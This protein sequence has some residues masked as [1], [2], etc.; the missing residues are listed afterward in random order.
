MFKSALSRR[1]L[2]ASVVSALA[3]ALAAQPGLAQSG[4]QIG[5]IR[6]DV[7]PLRANAGDPTA[8]WV[9]QELPAELARALAGRRAPNGAGLV[10]RI[11]YLSLGSSSGG[12]GPHGSTPDNISGVASIGG[13]QTP[14]RAA[15]YHYPSPVDQT[16]IEQSNR[17]RVSQLTQAL[18]YWIGQGAFF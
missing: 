3:V 1:A 9:Q 12:V 18:A 13:V 2:A 16:M 17:A 6:V 14:V 10:V 4:V 11:D 8:T 5:N 7:S 15:A